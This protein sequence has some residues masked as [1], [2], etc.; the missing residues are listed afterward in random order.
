[1]YV[2]KIPK[3]RPKI[4][5]ILDQIIDGSTLHISD[6]KLNRMLGIYVKPWH[7]KGFIGIYQDPLLKDTVVKFNVKNI[8][9]KIGLGKRVEYVIDDSFLKTNITI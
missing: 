4:I 6:V 8:E 7:R 5:D 2:L 3:N 9:K 1:M